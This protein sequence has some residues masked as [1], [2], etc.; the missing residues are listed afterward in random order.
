MVQTASEAA[1][2]AG[3]ADI[4]EIHQGFYESLPVPDASVDLVISNGVLNLAPDKGA[5]LNE[6]Y[7]VL[8]LAAASI[9]R[10]RW[11]SAS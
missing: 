11:C 6:V 2:E 1:R 7:R 9:W 10:T 8:K 3:L 5:V 4:V